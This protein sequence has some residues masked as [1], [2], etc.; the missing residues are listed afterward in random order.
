VK[1]LALLALALATALTACAGGEEPPDAE[2]LARAWSRALNAG[3]NQAAGAL[4]AVGARIEQT[5]LVIVVRTPEDAATWTATLPCSGRIVGVE[6]EDEEVTATFVL[7][8][9][10]TSA[11]DVPG[12]R[13]S[14]LF[15]VRDGK[16]VLFRQLPAATPPSET[17]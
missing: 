11:C 17:V 1:R 16:I 13:V 4:F 10:Q 3:D 8:D 12:G 6:G 2:E 14:A 9:R 5:G 7:A 15:R